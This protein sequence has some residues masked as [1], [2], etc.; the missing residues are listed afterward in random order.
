MHPSSNYDTECYE[1]KWKYKKKNKYTKIQKKYSTEKCSNTLMN[2][3]EKNYKKIGKTQ[4][5]L[6]K[7]KYDKEEK[8]T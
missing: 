2:H 1:P 4:R 8:K 5:P 6:T 3:S 7:K